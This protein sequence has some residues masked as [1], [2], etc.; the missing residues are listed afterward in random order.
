MGLHANLFF[1][2]YKYIELQRT[3][4]INLSR[5]LLYDKKK[6]WRKKYRRRGFLKENGKQ[7]RSPFAEKI[8]DSTDCVIVQARYFGSVHAY[9]KVRRLEGI[10]YLTNATEPVCY[11]WVCLLPQRSVMSHFEITSTRI[12]CYTVA[13]KVHE[14][15]YANKSS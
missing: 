1:V 4:I 13:F 6:F 9:S 15:N 12:F 8:D 7:R 5:R 2:R 10:C 14:M 11:S 3:I